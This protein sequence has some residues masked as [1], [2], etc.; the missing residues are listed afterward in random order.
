VLSACSESE[1]ADVNNTQSEGPITEVPDD[2]ERVDYNLVSAN[3]SGVTGTASF[4]PNDDGSTTV[5]IE[6]KGA[7]KE[8]HPAAINF[9]EVDSEGAVAITLE[10]CECAISE[11]VVDQLDNGTPVSFLELMTFDGHLNIYQSTTDA[12]K[13]AVSNIG[14]N[15]F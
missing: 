15:A 14:S 1:D 13:I 12:T 11:T 9:G 4:I 5:Y 8:L 3:D 2:P 10:V 6:L 7:T